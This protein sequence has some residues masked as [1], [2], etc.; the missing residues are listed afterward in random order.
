MTQPQLFDLSPGTDLVD[1][2]INAII[3]GD[4]GS[5]KT[6]L[7]TSLNWGTERWGEKA[8]YVPW[9]AGSESLLV[10]RPEDKEHLIRVNPRMMTQNGRVAFN[11]YKTA[12]D[13]ATA[14][15]KALAPEAKTIIWDG[16]TRLAEQILRGVANTGATVSQRKK[17]GGDETRLFFGEKG[18]PDYMALPIIADYGMAQFALMQ[19]SEALRQ[20][21][22][23]VLVLCVTDY[24]KPE[25]GA[26]ETETVGG[27]ALV[28]T[29]IIPKFMKDFDNVFRISLDNVTTKIEEQGKVP[30]FERQLKRHLWMQKDG[31]WGAKIRRPPTVNP[32]AKVELTPNPTEFWEWFD[33]QGLGVS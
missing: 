4:S 32:P 7:A 13:I 22:L 2:H 3:Y 24:Y 17:E 9:D 11:P 12:M 30:R 29:K 6:S 28:G 18:S 19:W 16:G 1:S 25:G 21:P 14:D 20:Q 31:I 26:V 10:V 8:L 33:N 15:W 27:P 23:N 5:G